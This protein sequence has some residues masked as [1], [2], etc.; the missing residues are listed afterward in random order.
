MKD[1]LAKLIPAGSI[2]LG[3]TTLFSYFLG[4]VRDHYF[5]QIFGLREP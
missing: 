3:I 2:V 4:L 1:R 5:A